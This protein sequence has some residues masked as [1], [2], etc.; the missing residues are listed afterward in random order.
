MA[1]FDPQEAR[2]DEPDYEAREA[3]EVACV[4]LEC[5]PARLSETIY[6]RWED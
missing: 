6:G 2:E 1:R 3:A 5:S 4:L